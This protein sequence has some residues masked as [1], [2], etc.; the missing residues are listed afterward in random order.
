MQPN[1][2]LV[3]DYL[4]DGY[5]DEFMSFKKSKPIALLINPIDFS[6]IEATLKEQQPM[7]SQ[8][9]FDIN[10]KTNSIVERI[11][12]IPY[13]K[14]TTTAKTELEFIIENIVK[15]DEEK[16]IRFYNL[17]QPM[18]SRMHVFELL[19]G[20]GKKNMWTI[21]D[22]RKNQKFESFEDFQNRV[23]LD[24]IHPIVKKILEEMK[25]ESKHNIFI[26]KREINTQRKPNFQNRR[27][28]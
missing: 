17:A 19:S 6:I 3:L 14:L 23:K 12:R 20:I 13:K 24:P 27:R 25:E 15:N 16:Y 28:Y 11:R 1:F 4:K 26:P 10:Y 5:P 8:D 7:Q 18:T 2:V 22:E 21:I 9:K